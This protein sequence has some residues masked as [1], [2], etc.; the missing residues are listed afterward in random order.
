MNL[1]LAAIFLDLSQ[2]YS[3]ANCWILSWVNTASKSQFSFPLLFL[4]VEN[5]LSPKRLRSCW[6]YPRT[7]C[8][9]IFW[10]QKKYHRIEKCLQRTVTV[11]F[12]ML[13]NVPLLQTKAA[14][15]TGK[16]LGDRQ[17][18]NLCRQI[19]CHNVLRGYSLP[20]SF[21]HSICIHVQT[22]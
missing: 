13:S 14:R 12:A 7:S 19:N 6:M 5:S 16:L 4:L 10:F 8:V 9:P 3:P 18:D 11:A 21:I 15:T 2:L 1:W 22:W 20:K 17:V